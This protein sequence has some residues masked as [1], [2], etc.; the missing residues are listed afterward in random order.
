MASED[1]TRGD[2]TTGVAVSGDELSIEDIARLVAYYRAKFAN[3]GPIY[4]AELLS[5]EFMT[6]Q[7]ARGGWPSAT[8][9]RTCRATRP[10]RSEHGERRVDGEPARRALAHGC[11][12]TDTRVFQAGASWPGSHL[13]L[14]TWCASPVG[15]GLGP[16]RVTSTRR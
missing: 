9:Q 4:L 3:V 10:G 15:A 11:K 14:N 6:E 7:R 5:T 16:R 2:P 8:G 13:T 12:R 1:P